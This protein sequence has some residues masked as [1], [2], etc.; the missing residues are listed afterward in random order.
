MK[1]NDMSVSA[2]STQVHWLSLKQSLL[3]YSSRTAHSAFWSPFVHCEITQDLYCECL[4]I[5]ASLR[6]WKG[7]V[8]VFDLWSRGHVSGVWIQLGCQEADKVSVVSHATGSDRLWASRAVRERC[9][10]LFPATD[11]SVCLNLA[12]HYLCLSQVIPAVAE[13]SCKDSFVRLVVQLR[14]HCFSILFGGVSL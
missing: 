2:F 1:R 11:G 4:T 10:Y 3:G 8:Y 6:Q 5:K 12:V 13:V 9:L 7:S 14:K